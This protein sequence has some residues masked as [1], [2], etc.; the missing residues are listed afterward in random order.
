MQPYI[1]K[2][3]MAIRLFAIIFLITLFSACKDELPQEK[4][5]PQLNFGDLLKVDL[6][7]YVGICLSGGSGF[8]TKAENTELEKSPDDGNEGE[9][10]LAPGTHHY[11]VIY[12]KD[13]PFNYPLAVIP[14]SFSGEDE[15]YD[16]PSDNNITLTADFLVVSGSMKSKFTSLSDLKNIVFNADNEAF[17]LVNFAGNEIYREGTSVAID[18]G[19]SDAENLFSI[20]RYNFLN[21]PLKDY[22]ITAPDTDGVE[23][24]WFTMSNSVYADRNGNIVTDYTLYPDNVFENAE[25]AIGNPV[26][27]ARVE[28]LAVRYNV[29]FTSRSQGITNDEDILGYDEIDAET[30]LPVYNIKINHYTGETIGQ[31]YSIDYEDKDAQVKVL[32]YYL[33]NIEKS[34][35]AIKKLS[36]NNFYFNNWSMPTNYRSYWS[37]DPNYFLLKAAYSSAKGYPHQFRQ[38]LE[39]DTVLQLHGKEY[40]WDDDD[41]VVT[42]NRKVVSRD[43][44]GNIVR[45]EEGNAL[46]H[47]E[48]VTFYTDLGTQVNESENAECVLRYLSF[49]DMSNAY[50]NALQKLNESTATDLPAVTLYSLENTYYDPGMA[51]GG[52]AG[53][54]W[55]WNWE[56]AAYSAATNLTMLCELV[57]PDE[58]S[59]DKTVYRGQNNIFYFHLPD[60]LKSKLKIFNEVILQAGNAGINILH[61]Y[62]A[63]HGFLNTGDDS[64]HNT[65]LEK[66]AWNRGSVLWI[67]EVEDEGWEIGESREMT[68]DDLRLIPAEISGGDGQCLIAPKRMGPNVKFYLAPILKNSAGHAI[69]NQGEEI[70][71][72]YIRDRSNSVEISFNHLVALIHKGIGPIDVFKDGKMYYSIPIPHRVTNPVMTGDNPIWKTLGNIGVVRNNWYNINVTD[73]GSVGTPVH[74]LS[75]P[76]VPVMDI[77]RSYINADIKVYG[78]HTISQDNIE[79]Q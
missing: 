65:Y 75:Q 58:N 44:E 35:Y 50:A 21:L 52:V 36:A 25:D 33:N 26:L 31:G 53:G 24:E 38:A 18:N 70:E 79:M 1:E 51:M 32:G 54:N 59:T 9:Y 14:M 16:F 23:K 3:R 63:S 2:L 7:G 41:Y 8:A 47:D 71:S 48:P 45:D 73:I 15:D 76:I 60:L 5:N 69:N 11:V 27:T 6:D 68:E 66:V 37:E 34:T 62:F 74:D 64:F 61:A 43:H 57:I 72:G 28:R 22:K 46:Y 30:H 42:V 20:N 29:T 77:R 12:E 55:V 39:T 17:V 19:K 49:N 10:K 40:S 13:K 67:G 78:W 4:D 56:K